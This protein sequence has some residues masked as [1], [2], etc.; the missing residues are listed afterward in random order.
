MAA[1]LQ[2][3]IETATLG[4]W[5]RVVNGGPFGTVAAAAKRIRERYVPPDC[6]G[7][8]MCSYR[9][10]NTETGD[11]RNARGGFIYEPRGVDD[12]MPRLAKVEAK[13][14]KA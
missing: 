6:D 14:G 5:H 9:I 7:V 12:I 1:K 10:R 8:T 2:W 11:L 4:T 13:D 3:I